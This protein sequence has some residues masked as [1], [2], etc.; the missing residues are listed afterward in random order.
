MV[1]V[2]FFGFFLPCVCISWGR[3]LN[4]VKLVDILVVAKPTLVFRRMKGNS[5]TTVPFLQSLQVKKT[6]SFLEVPKELQTPR[7]LSTI[8][9]EPLCHF[10]K[11]LV[12][13]PTLVFRRIKGSSGTTVAFLQI[14]KVKKPSENQ[15]T[16]C[17]WKNPVITNPV[18]LEEPSGGF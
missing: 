18:F 7:L 5:G 11:H 4:F 15:Q 6:T 13:K 1:E 3:F 16:Q 10:F 2:N 17:S 9:E 14:S 8:A 12:A